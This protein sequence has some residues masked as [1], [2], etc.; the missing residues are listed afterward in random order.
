[1]ASKE[2]PAAVCSVSFSKLMQGYALVFQK[3]FSS[4]AW[5]TLVGQMR[6]LQVTVEGASFS[7]S[8]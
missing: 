6:L 3:F 2:K 1:M 4:T 8:L 7:C 5:V